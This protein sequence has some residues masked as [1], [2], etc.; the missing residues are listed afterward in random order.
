[1]T[2]TSYA[3]TTLTTTAGTKGVSPGAVGGIVAGIVVGFLLLGAAALFFIFRKRSEVP[4]YNYAQ[5]TSQ[6]MPSGLNYPEDKHSRSSRHTSSINQF[7]PQV[8][9]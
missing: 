5:G 8:A 7:P 6:Q 2:T 3:T 9:E 4:S 1:M